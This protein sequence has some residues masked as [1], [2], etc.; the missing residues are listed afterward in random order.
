MNVFSTMN[1]LLKKQ[2]AIDDGD[3]GRPITLLAGAVACYIAYGLGAGFFQG[4]WTLAMALL[5]VPLIIL[6][7]LALC[8]PSLYV[9]TALAGG[10]YSARAF[11]N[12]V[13][14]FCGIA[15]LILV[16]L[17]PVSWLFSVS[18]MSLAFVVWLH[19]FVWLTALFFGRQFLV[20]ATGPG[21]KAIGIWLVI[22][23]VVSLQMTTYVRPVLWRDSGEPLFAKE[24]KSF[25]THFGDVVSWS[26]E[27]PATPNSTTRR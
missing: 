19:V 27:P 22:L 10:D 18:T 16:A 12:I 17:V 4:G 5:K 15:G 1:A 13:A 11:A 2:H 24:K 25:F 23:F 7:S 14:G 26:L 9:F 3:A 20:N 6:G 21:R 8:L